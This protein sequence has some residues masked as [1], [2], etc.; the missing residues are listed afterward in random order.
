MQQ[1]DEI[2]GREQLRDTVR[3]VVAESGVTASELARRAGLAPSTLTKFLNDDGARHVLTTRTLA[4]LAAA[5]GRRLAAAGLDAIPREVSAPLPAPPGHGA[6]DVPVLG[7]AR[8]GRDGLF[9]DNGLVESYVPRPHV[10]MRVPHA[11]ALYMNS[12]SQEPVFRHGDLLYVNPSMPPRSGDDVLI[13]LAGGEA[14]VKRLLRRSPR[15]IVVQQFN[16]ACELVF[17]AAEVSKVHI[18][19]A[20]IKVRV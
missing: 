10:L 18:V 16:P 13:E 15:E 17:D 7:Q 11:Y 19:V 6:S 3:A 9:I 4:K 5:T 1:T 2:V 14:Y 12:D 20:V 8:G